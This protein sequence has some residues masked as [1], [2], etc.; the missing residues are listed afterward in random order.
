MYSC[1]NLW[2]VDTLLFI[3]DALLLHNRAVPELRQHLG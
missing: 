1:L 2:F 3:V